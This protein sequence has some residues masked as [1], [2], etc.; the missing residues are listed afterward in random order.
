ME[1]QD[2]QSYFS[3]E[4]HE[5][6]QIWRIE[7][8]NPKKLASASGSFHKGDS[9]IVLKKNPESRS[10]TAHH[11]VGSSSSQDEY[12]AAA[13]L[14]VKLAS[15]L[16]QK[17][18]VYQEWE[19]NESVLFLSYFPSGVKYLE[20][21][22]DSGFNIVKPEQYKPRLLQIKGKTHIRINQVPL[23]FESLN[24]NDAFI[25]DAGLEL[26]LWVGKTANKQE[27]SKAT[28]AVIS[29]RDNERN[30]QAQIRYP[31][32]NQED[33]KAFWQV[34]GGNKGNIK[35]E[36]EKKDEDIDKIVVSANIKFFEVSNSDGQL[37]QTEITERPLSKNMLKSEETYIL[38]M[39][40]DIYVWTGRKSNAEE[41]ETGLKLANEYAQKSGKKKQVRCVRVFEG[42]E[43]VV[44]RMNFKDWPS[45]A[46]HPS[47]TL[48]EAKEKQEVT[49]QIDFDQ[50]HKRVSEAAYDTVKK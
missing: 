6:L 2:L 17:V 36:D 27:K 24:E 49:V 46:F 29:I 26:F 43:D 8:F 48:A 23:A 15:F 7:Q 22:V 41:K 39:E 5:I 3:F 4:S 35:A 32:D 13:I 14:V 40:N 1:N 31:R 47:S 19:A 44:F 50:M 42:M 33:E 20:G 12:G 16:N 9:Y 45:N 21:G 11:W 28:F 30:A 38:A 10:Y 34:L 18:N 25:L 37:T